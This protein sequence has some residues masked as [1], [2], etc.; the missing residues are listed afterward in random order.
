MNFSSINANIHNL[1]TFLNLLKARPKPQKLQK[2]QNFSKIFK[3]EFLISAERLNQK[4][5][6]KKTL[7]TFFKISEIS[8]F[9]Q[10]SICH[11]FIFFR[12]SFFVC[13]C[14][15]QNLYFAFVSNS[16]KKYDFLCLCFLSI[17]HIHNIS[18][19]CICKMKRWQN[20]EFSLIFLTKEGQ[21]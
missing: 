19:K 18:I 16:L 2:S 20:C 12:D 10:F 11:F 5:R 3:S 6:N 21:K 17:K 13:L 8:D 14:F 9:S 15:F 1:K 4:L 7:N